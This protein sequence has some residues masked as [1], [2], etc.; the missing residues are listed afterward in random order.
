MLRALFTA[1][2]GAI[3]GLLFVVYMPVIG[4]LAVLE[5]SALWIWKQLSDRPT[6]NLIPLGHDDHVHPTLPLV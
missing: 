2:K 3:L 4:F 5:C 6:R 1:C